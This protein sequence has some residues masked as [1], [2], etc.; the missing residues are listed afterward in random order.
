[1]DFAKRIR[2]LRLARGLSQSELSKKL[3]LSK[4]RISMYEIGER[5][6]DFE[7]LELIADYF[8]VDMDYLLGKRDNSTYIISPQQKAIVDYI[9]GDEEL[10]DL[11]RKTRDSS[12]RQRLLRW[13]K[14]MEEYDK[15]DK[16]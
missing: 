5:Q 9:A 4:S 11:L 13:V 10:L 15:E 14:L 7:T 12:Y 2:E 8:N 6:P 1:M 3:G 16:G